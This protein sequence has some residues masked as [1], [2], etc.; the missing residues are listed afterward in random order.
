MLTY[1]YTYHKVFNPF[2]LGTKAW[3]KCSWSQ[4]ALLTSLCAICKFSFDRVLAH[5]KHN[6]K[7]FF[8]S[9]SITS[10]FTLLG[11]T[12][13]WLQY[14]VKHKAH[15]R[16]QDI[17]IHQWMHWTLSNKSKASQKQS[18]LVKTC[19]RDLFIPTLIIWFSCVWWVLSCKCV[20]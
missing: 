16:H 20:L 6:I 13:S 1:A 17:L 9:C 3:K 14:I 12:C 7:Q 11:I 2:T 10:I 5:I 19:C 4:S 8:I 18:T 15:V